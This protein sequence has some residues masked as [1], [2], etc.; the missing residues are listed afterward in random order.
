MF[1]VFE[2]SFTTRFC[3][4]NVLLWCQNFT[5]L[6]VRMLICSL[7][8]IKCVVSTVTS[9]KLFLKQSSLELS[10]KLFFFKQLYLYLDSEM[11]SWDMFL[12]VVGLQSVQTCASNV[13]LRELSVGV[14][15]RSALLQPSDLIFL[16]AICFFA[17]NR[18]FVS[19]TKTW[20]I[21]ILLQKVIL[22]VWLSLSGYFHM[23]VTV[24]SMI[25]LEY[26]SVLT[27]VMQWYCS[28]T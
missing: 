3:T 5:N 15:G 12:L 19:H 4:S 21:G 11:G 16:W 17:C 10:V 14:S 2:D 7:D 22:L 28:C 27:Y 8:D 20:D 26:L 13:A 25:I 24:K 1:R 18:R 6:M 9:R 23:C